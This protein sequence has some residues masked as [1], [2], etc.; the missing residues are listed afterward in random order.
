[1]KSRFALYSASGADEVARVRLVPVPLLALERDAFTPLLAPAANLLRA[2][3]VVR[4]VDLLRAVAVLRAPAL[5]RAVDFLPV[6]RLLPARGPDR[7]VAMTALFAKN[8][9]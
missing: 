7:L 9:P 8:M 6:A 4:A 2:S 1:V 5:V 3:L